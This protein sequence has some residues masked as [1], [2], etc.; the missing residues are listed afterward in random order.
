MKSSVLIAIFAL[1]VNRCWTAEPVNHPD[2]LTV[3][4]DL[5]NPALTNG[6]PAPEK[7]VLQSLPRYAGTKVAHAIYLPADWKPGKR[8][9]VIIEY[10]GN[11]A[12]VREYRGI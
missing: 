1:A 6:E 3:P 8:Y 12:T 7:A 10:L 5:E 4:A 2:V 11:T 9:P